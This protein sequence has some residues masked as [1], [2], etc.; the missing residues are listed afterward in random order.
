MRSIRYI[1]L[2][3][4]L[5]CSP[6]FAQDQ[7]ESRAAA[8]DVSAITEQMVLPEKSEILTVQE[9]DF[10]V[11]D[12]NAPVTIIEYASF[13]CS[14]CADF[15]NHTYQDLKTKYIDTGKVQFVFRSFP[16]N[17]P[18]A[19]AS[20]LVACA[21][22]ESKAKFIKVLFSTQN[23]WAFKKNFLEVL[24]NIAKLG[25]ISQERFEQCIA[26]SDLEHKIT[27]TRFYAAKVL[28]VRATPTFYINGTELSGAK[29][30]EA[31]SKAIDEALNK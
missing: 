27:E 21:P 23:N 4:T 15:H 29:N 31:F 20:M 22:D 1:A 12:E 30:L 19:R 2:L 3:I 7:T 16:L 26:D 13:S 6:V 17:E 9:D 25:G 5:I 8:P 14:H 11:G 10:V 18:A 24:S 28:E